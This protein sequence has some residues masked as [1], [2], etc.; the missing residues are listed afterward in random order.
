MSVRGRGATSAWLPRRRR[1]PARALFPA[2][3]SPTGFAGER[4][5]RRGARPARLRPE[6][7]DPRADSSDGS[8]GGLARSRRGTARSRC[9]AGW[10]R[11]NAGLVAA[12][13]GGSAGAPPPDGWRV[14]SV[15]GVLPLSVGLTRPRL[16][17]FAHARPHNNHTGTGK[18]MHARTHARC[19]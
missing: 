18:S 3:R 9:K 5:W 8:A 10:L 6:R 13:P 12:R 16:A 15:A 14:G 2:G 11:R 1:R 19:Q 17:I 4:S 7:S